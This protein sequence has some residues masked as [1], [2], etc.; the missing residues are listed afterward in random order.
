MEEILYL[1]Q[2]QYNAYLLWEDISHLKHFPSRF[3]E[4]MSCAT[5]DIKQLFM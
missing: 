4:M 2:L 5:S 1:Y 3:T